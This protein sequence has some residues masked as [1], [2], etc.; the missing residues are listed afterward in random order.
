MSGRHAPP[1]THRRWLAILP[2]VL[3]CAL[4]SAVALLP[5]VTRG[6]ADDGSHEAR[7]ALDIGNER[8]TPT[9]HRTPTPT[10]RA[11]RTATP[12]PSKVATSPAPPVPTGST[13][14]SSSTPKAAAAPSRPSVSNSRYRMW[15]M[16]GLDVTDAH[17][18]AAA[19]QYAVVVMKADDQ[20][21]A[22]KLS[23][24][25]P[26]VKILCYKDL[27]S[28]RDYET[29]AVAAGVAIGPARDRGWL[30]L[31]KAG[32]PIAWNGFGGHWQAA[33]WNAD[34]QAQWAAGV[35]EQLRNSPFDGVLA[36]NDMSTLGHYSD[37][38]LAGTSSHDATDSLI[39]Q[40]LDQL[41]ATAGRKLSQEGKILVPNISDGR[42]NPGRWSN[43]AR[44]GG[45]MEEN[46][47]NWGYGSSPQVWDWG[48]GGWTD[49]TRLIAQG[50]RSLAV[51]QG[52]DNRTLLYGYT[53]FLLQATPGD[54]WMPATE[55][56]YESR[57]RIDEE[58]IAIGAPLK[59]TRRLGSGAWTR[60]FEGGT[61]LVNPTT[62]A[63]TVPAPRGHTHDG[64]PAGPSVHLE[65]K[66]GVILEA[67]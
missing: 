18:R 51:T 54:A 30:A 32:D 14:P 12:S 16:I 7:R 53:S 41:I 17:V 60:P 58:T 45:G 62:Q 49:Q 24:A 55:P 9:T 67:S 2:A 48:L 35:S 23:R 28:V 61:V 40:G 42:L 13:Q 44:W 47:A 36:D 15:S 26:T 64:R 65:P 29:T 56:G 21:A 33:V 6:A 66:S 10:S 34:Y 25:D 11:T 19:G 27:A 46:F 57:A 63:L 50:P 52:S 22:A 31:D 39:R 38:L 5:D 20:A 8:A 43:H 1:V 3:L 59:P 37:A 4:V